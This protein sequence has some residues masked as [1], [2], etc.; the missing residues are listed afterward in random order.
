MTNPKAKNKKGQSEKST[1]SFLYQSI[2]AFYEFVII[3]LK[4]NWDI[5]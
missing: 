2:G 3:A 5:I 1:L 4:I